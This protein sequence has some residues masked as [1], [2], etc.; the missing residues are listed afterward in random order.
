MQQNLKVLIVGGCFPVQENI[1]EEKLYHQLLKNKIKYELQLDIDIKVLRYEKLESVYKKIWNL[2]N[3]EKVNIIIFHIRIEQVL[4]IIKFYLRYYT[5]DN[6]YHRGI[7]LVILGNCL[8]EKPEFSL[9]RINQNVPKQHMHLLKTL[10]INVN[11]ILGYLV[12]NQLYAFQKYKSQ[13]GKLMEFG[14]FN[15]VKFIFTGPV[16]RPNRIIENFTSYLLDV[17]MQKIVTKR[18]GH[19]IRLWGKYEND[20]F[21]F[22]DDNIKVNESGHKR[23]S[24]II[25]K[26]F[27]L[28]F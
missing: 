6:N 19:Y 2:V 7:N 23:V 13:I 9:T 18:K 11:Y 14:K 20:V 28:N 12:F 24:E 15:Q 16:S 1:P 22:C 5:K 8:A 21:L 3:Q 10:F 26:Y 4:R 27:Q 17:Y 25:F